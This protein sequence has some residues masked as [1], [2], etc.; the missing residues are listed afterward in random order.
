[1]KE[2]F[3]NLPTLRFRK[4]NEFALFGEMES[5][6]KP[7][8]FAPGRSFVLQNHRFY[9]RDYCTGVPFS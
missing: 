5:R 9:L 3:K 1:M 7:A 4:S 8:K 2:H 6:K